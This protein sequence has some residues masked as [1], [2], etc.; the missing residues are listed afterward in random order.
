MIPLPRFH[1]F[2]LFPL[3]EEEDG[4]KNCCSNEAFAFKIVSLKNRD[5]S[6]GDG[7]WSTPRRDF[8][9]KCKFVSVGLGHSMLNR[10]NL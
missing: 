6:K 2:F 8:G 1:F 5:R 7:G 10:Y 3:L 4:C 9:S